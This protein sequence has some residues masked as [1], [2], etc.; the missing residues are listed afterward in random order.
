MNIHTA[1]AG[2]FAASR[3][4]A[5]WSICGTAYHATAKAIR[6]LQAPGSSSG[7][8]GRVQ[9]GAKRPQDHA[10]YSNTTGSPSAKSGEVM[11]TQREVHRAE[12]LTLNVGDPEQQMEA[13]AGR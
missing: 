10:G 2:L 1:P 9:P 7:D 8:A 6:V 13:L 4:S 5:S 3:V 11:M 12:G